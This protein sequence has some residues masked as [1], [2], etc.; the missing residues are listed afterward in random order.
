MFSLC[1]FLLAL[2]R[3]EQKVMSQKR[4]LSKNHEYDIYLDLSIYID[5]ALKYIVG[6]LDPN[7]SGRSRNARS[8]A[9]RF[10]GVL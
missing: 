2:G 9:Q 6:F 5:P 3:T 10:C 8:R 7:L 1:A 4:T